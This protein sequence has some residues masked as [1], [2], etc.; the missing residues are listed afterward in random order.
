MTRPICLPP[1]LFEEV[2]SLPPAQ[3][4]A[5]RDELELS[6]LPEEDAAMVREHLPKWRAA[7]RQSRENPERFQDAF[8]AMDEI[9]AELEAYRKRGA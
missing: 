1:R 9:E 8:E 2:L 5:L 6:L 7:S 4:E 3:R